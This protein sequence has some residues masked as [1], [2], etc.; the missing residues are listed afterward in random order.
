MYKCIYIYTYITHRNT[1]TF[2]NHLST[3]HTLGTMHEV[4]S[5]THYIMTFNPYAKLGKLYLHFTVEPNE[6]QSS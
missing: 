5:F 2:N 1:Y 4:K 3:D 6:A